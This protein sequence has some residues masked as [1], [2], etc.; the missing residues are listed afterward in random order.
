MF[1][2]VQTSVPIRRIRSIRVP[3]PPG[4]RRAQSS[5][6]PPDSVHP[7]PR[8]RSFVLA[9]T[10]FFTTLDRARTSIPPTA[11]IGFRAFFH[12]F[13]RYHL[14][15]VNYSGSPCHPPEFLTP[16]PATT[17]SNSSSGAEPDFFT[18]TPTPLVNNSPP[19]P[20]APLRFCGLRGLYV[21][22]VGT[23]ALRARVGSPKCSSLARLSTNAAAQ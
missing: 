12:H 14:L 10:D 3:L 6:M 22:M 8:T 4:R 11:C 1:T 20:A 7:Q 17:C 15:L 9:D 23:P 16:A 18:T 5:T 19:S 21:S 13:P 2:S